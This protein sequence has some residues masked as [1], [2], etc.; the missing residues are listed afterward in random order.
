MEKHEN[1][2]KFNKE[3]KGFTL[4][5]LIVV[6]VILAILAAILVPACLGFIDAAHRKEELAHAKALCAAVQSKLSTLYDQGIMPNVDFNNYGN[7]STTSGGFSWKKDWTSDVI[8]SSGIEKK[9]YV[10]GFACGNLSVR[11]DY[12]DMVTYYQKGISALKK[13][14]TVYVF[15]YMEEA[16]S[17]PIFCID[18]TWGDEPPVIVDTNHQRNKYVRVKSEEEPVYLSAWY[19]LC[20][21]EGPQFNANVSYSYAENASRK[22]H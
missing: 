8:Y 19:V 17:D 12:Q 22:K 7:Q 5:E 9:P 14:Y 13:G 4:V 6:M 20:G 21:C 2:R 11:S 10:C 15:F 3:Q 18:G 16:D 1:A